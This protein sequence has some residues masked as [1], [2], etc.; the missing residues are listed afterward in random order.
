MSSCVWLSFAGSE[1]IAKTG[2]VGQTLDEAKH[3]NKSLSALGNVIN[4]LTSASAHIPYRDSKLT[5]LLSDSLGGNSKTCLIVTCSPMSTNVDET[6]STLRFG[7]RAKMIKNK[8]KVN[9]EKSIAEYKRLL[10]AANEKIAIQEQI[11]L[12]LEKDVEELM[13]C[14]QAVDP[15]HLKKPIPQL[16]SKDMLIHAVQL[17]ED[18]N[19]IRNAIKPSPS[20]PSLA[21]V[22]SSSFS[23][24]SALSSSASSLGVGALG[25]ST[26]GTASGPSSSVAPLSPASASVSSSS[27]VPGASAEGFAPESLMS[28]PSRLAALTIE[29]SALENKLKDL[30]RE[31]ENISDALAERERELEEA[32][33]I[34]AMEKEILTLEMKNLLTELEG[35]RKRREDAESKARQLAATE[36]DMALLKKKSEISEREHQIQILELKEDKRNLSA[37]LMEALNEINERY[38]DGFGVGTPPPAGMPT[39]AA[40]TAGAAAATAASNFKAATGIAS[41]LGGID[42]LDSR[43]KTVSS[44]SAPSGGGFY[45]DPNSSVESLTAA[46]HR[47]TDQ[48]LQL[49]MAHQNS[50]EHISMLEVLLAESN[51]RLKEAQDAPAARIRELEDKL[52][53]AESLCAKLVESGKFWKAERKAN[54]KGDKQKIKVS[55]G[56]VPQVIQGGKNK[57]GA[58]DP[59]APTQTAKQDAMS[60]FF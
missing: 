33:E 26:L 55:A 42:L 19:V 10:A 41:A 13:S 54:Q 58:A 38:N 37:K 53:A 49:S 36:A 25:A 59:N 56:P 51:A 43:R 45:V 15:Q 27:S 2:A 1:K 32:N 3:I 22:A 11:I 44:P 47:K 57:A 31:K 21:S 35:E 4:S 29:K 18:G 52:L 9:Q 34:T 39:G 48:Y 8:P 20:N 14:L 50:G 6:I 17:D 16:K 7:T 5:R 28:L 24:S 46:L 30:R 60:M 12:A 23:P 40:A